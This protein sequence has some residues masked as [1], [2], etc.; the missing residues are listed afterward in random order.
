MPS[1][2]SSVSLSSHSL[3]IFSW[4]RRDDLAVEEV[5]RVDANEHA[6]GENQ[7]T[8][9]R[10]GTKPPKRESIAARPDPIG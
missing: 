1:R 7:V 8:G 4:T 9:L 3:R 10:H 5:H 6:E 2:P